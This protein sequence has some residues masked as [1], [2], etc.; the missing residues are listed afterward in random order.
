MSEADTAVVRGNSAAFSA[1]DVEAMLTFYAVDAEVIDRRRFGFGRFTGHDE[2]RTYYGG[3]VGT[4]A[5]LHEDL[6]VLGSVG[7]VV[8]AHCELSGHLASDP[9]GPVV[10]A[11]YGLLV[12]LRDGLIARL[13]VF[14]DGEAAM[15][16]ARGE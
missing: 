3:I 1:R 16:A 14:D 6:E 9:T 5:D 7:G 12:T 10:G 13:E 2:L 15:E 4:A 11:T 8:V